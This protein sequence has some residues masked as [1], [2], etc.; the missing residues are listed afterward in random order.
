MEVFEINDIIKILVENRYTLTTFYE[1]YV[2]PKIHKISYFFSDS[3]L[4]YF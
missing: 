3:K 2:P 1:R 4:I